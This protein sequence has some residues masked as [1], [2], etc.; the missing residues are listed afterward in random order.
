MEKPSNLLAKFSIRG[1]PYEK[2]D[3]ISPSHEVFR[4]AASRDNYLHSLAISVKDENG[5]LFDFEGFPLEFE[6]EIK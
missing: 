3:Y 4:D 5:D 1:Q 6:I 2:I